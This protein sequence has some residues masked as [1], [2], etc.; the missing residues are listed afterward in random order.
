MRRLKYFL[1]LSKK[2]VVDRA[3][4]FEC[5]SPNH[6]VR[7]PRKFP[8]RREVASG[9]CAGAG[10][11]TLAGVL[12]LRVVRR[13]VRQPRLLDPWVGIDRTVG[14]TRIC[15]VSGV[16]CMLGGHIR[17]TRRTAREDGAQAWTVWRRMQCVGPVLSGK[18][19][20]GCSGV[21]SAR[22]CCGWHGWRAC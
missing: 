18:V 22:G 21:V 15:A 6:P 3:R 1:V 16:A 19:T 4:G 10:L 17:Q 12:S 20:K 5:R 8:A 9:V 7:F 14:G 11:A 13:V 2:G